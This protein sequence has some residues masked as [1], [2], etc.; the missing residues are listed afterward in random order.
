MWRISHSWR[1]G[2]SI[3]IC[4]VLAA[5]VNASASI[6]LFLSLYCFSISNASGYWTLW[7]MANFFRLDRQTSCYSNVRF[8]RMCHCV[9]VACVCTYWRCFTLGIFVSSQYKFCICAYCTHTHTPAHAP[10]HVL[11]NSA[12]LGINLK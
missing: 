9:C 4:T 7:Q 2:G 11:W 12:W 6:T 10:V 1:G 3:L 8:V 5:T